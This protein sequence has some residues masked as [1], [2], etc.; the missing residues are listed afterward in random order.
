MKLTDYDNEYKKSLSDVFFEY[1]KSFNKIKDEY[2]F[3]LNQKDISEAIILRLKIYYET[4]TNIKNFLDKR[5]LTA[6]SDFFVESTLFFLKLFLLKRG[7]ILRA[8]SERKISKSKTAMRP[9]ISIWKGEEL[10][11]VIECKTQLGWNRTNWKEQFSMREKTLTNE[12]P[13]AKSFLLVMTSSN[14]SG[15][16]NDSEHSLKFYCLLNDIWPISYQ[17]ESDILNPIEGLFE[18]LDSLV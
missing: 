11:C 16:D 4:Q 7:N 12:F 14:W 17:N 15:F 2:I 1:E 13:N 3:D 6:A 5:Y 18:Q 8:E 9:D 10:V